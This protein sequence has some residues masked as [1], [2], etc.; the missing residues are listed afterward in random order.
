MHV[1]IAKDCL[2]PSSWEE[3]QTDTPAEFIA[4]QMAPGVK[5]Y[6]NEVT[7]QHE[8]TPYD[9]ASI[10]ALNEESED[11]TLIAIQFPKVTGLL[12][13]GTLISIAATAYSL[14]QINKIEV[15]NQRNTNDQSPNNSLSSRSN[16][17]R[18]NARIPDIFGQVRATPDLIGL[19]YK[20]FEDQREVEY[21]YMCVGRGDFEVTD[22]REDTT[23]VGQIAGT[24]V[25]VYCPNSSPVSSDDTGLAVRIGTPISEPL[26]DV[27]RLSSVNGQT[28][29]P[30]RSA[31]LTGVSDIEFEF[32][33][34]VRYTGP[35]TSFDFTESFTA[36]SQITISGPGSIGTV[37]RAFNHT[38]KVSAEYLGFGANAGILNFQGGDARD[39]RVGDFLVLNMTFPEGISISG[40]LF[41]VV[42]VQDTFVVL[43]DPAVQDSDWNQ[44]G[45]LPND[46]T[47]S[48]TTSYQTAAPSTPS[49]NFS[50]DKYKVLASTTTELI[51]ENPDNVNPDWRLFSPKNQQGGSNKIAASG[52]LNFYTTE[53]VRAIGSFD[54]SGDF[55]EAIVNYTALNGLYKDDGSDREAIDVKVRA[56]VKPL[57]SASN[58]IGDAVKFDAVISGT[59]QDN[60]TASR[61]Y[62]QY[63]DLNSVPEFNAALGWRVEIFRT[64]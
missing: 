8:V 62:T 63:I 24:S 10:Q 6:R 25:E 64:T 7:E 52:T 42:D 37:N 50:T 16:T 4:E 9:E 19:P 44:I 61:S 34:I 58:A 1:I 55:D 33:N 46:V 47:S 21:S 26:R 49:F 51:L 35:D 12:I 48:I 38:A 20:V 36:G 13:V 60:D 17:A 15:P 29:Q 5:V 39:L 14:Y 53:T 27:V 41:E 2:D 18:P 59:A 32:P 56:L 57:D 45:T 30:P 11:D 28:L 40:S 22:I 43:A 23:P 31:F 54:I 3:F